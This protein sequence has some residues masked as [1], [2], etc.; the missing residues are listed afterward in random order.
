MRDLV[1]LVELLLIVCF[2]LRKLGFRYRIGIL[3][4]SVLV[5]Y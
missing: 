3:S 1:N 5:T 2:W 4:S